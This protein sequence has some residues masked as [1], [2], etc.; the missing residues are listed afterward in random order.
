MRVYQKIYHVCFSHFYTTQFLTNLKIKREPCI[1]RILYNFDYDQNQESS[2]LF[3]SNTQNSLRSTH[4]CKNRIVLYF[5][6]LLSMRFT[7][8]LHVTTQEVVSYTTFSPLLKIT[9][10]VYFLLHYLLTL[11]V[12]QTLSGIVSERVRTCLCYK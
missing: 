3:L 10:A 9:L 12:I 7:H 4:K 11:I 5:L 2:I 1:S 6:T 8:T